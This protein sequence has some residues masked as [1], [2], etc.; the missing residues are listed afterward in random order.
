MKKFYTSLFI[1]FCF[2]TLQ[3]QTFEFSLAYVGVNSST[4]NHQMAFIATP[5]ASVTNG[6]TADLG[7]G[8]YVPSGLTIG[9]FVQ[10]NS[11]LPASE[12]SSLSL[13]SD[14]YFLARVEAGSSS[15]ILNG[16]GPFQLVL[17]DIIADPNPT[18]GQVI[19]VENGDPVFDTLFVQNYLNINLGS[20][21]TDAYLQNNPAANNVDFSTLSNKSYELTQVSV[22]PN[23][24]SEVINIETNMQLTKVEL[25]DILGKRVL[26]TNATNQLNI[27]QFKAGVYF[28]KVH[29]GTSILTKKIIIE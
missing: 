27:K 24:T 26:N 2:V 28:L 11:G 20:G 18:S 1:L 12:W 14:A 3:A 4:N 29:A 21:T 9:N 6:V 5:S 8:F 17:F 22:Y 23:P 15:V 19:F 10:G 16:A 13:G 25:F 7:G